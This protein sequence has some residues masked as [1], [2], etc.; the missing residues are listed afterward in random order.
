MKVRGF[1]PLLS[2]LLLAGCQLHRPWEA[3]EKCRGNLPEASRQAVVV[4]REKGSPSG[5]ALR[6]YE[7][8]KD[9]WQ[10]LGA[11][12]PAVAGRNGVARPGEKRE[13]DGRTPSGI[14]ALERGFG[15]E[16]LSTK[17]PYILLAPEMIW[18]DDA[19]SD[20]YNTLAEKREGEGLSYEIMKRADDL[21]KYGIVVEYNTKAIVPGAGSAI[22][23]HIWSSTATPTAGCIAVAEPDMIRML[24]WLDPAQHPLAVIGDAC[25]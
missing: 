20:R 12:I 6:L 15:Y 14:F 23:F 5:M 25:P 22:F 11:A 1:V 21:Y 13:G 2:L 9:G 17:M 4:D 24:H 3:F 8:G 7:R 18:I 10:P 19:R 16:P